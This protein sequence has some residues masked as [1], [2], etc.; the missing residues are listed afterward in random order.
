MRM[1]TLKKQCS[2]EENNKIIY[3][4]F[5]FFVAYNSC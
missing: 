1:D 3:E 2:S 4:I 5:L